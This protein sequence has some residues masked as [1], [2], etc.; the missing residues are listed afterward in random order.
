M[1]SFS[2]RFQNHRH[3]KQLIR[4]LGERGSFRASPAEQ[5]ALQLSHW[6]MIALRDNARA[7]RQIADDID[8]IFTKAVS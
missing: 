4:V 2:K 6:D 8:A 7:L 3:G 5:P 1:S